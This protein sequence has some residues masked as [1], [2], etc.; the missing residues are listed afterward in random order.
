MHILHLCSLHLH[1][2]KKVHLEYWL[3]VQSCCEMDLC[4]IGSLVEGFHTGAN[5]RRWQGVHPNPLG[6]KLHCISSIS[7]TDDKEAIDKEEK[8]EGNSL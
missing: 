8:C 3:Q 6:K 4:T 1:G 5:L 2:E 7:S